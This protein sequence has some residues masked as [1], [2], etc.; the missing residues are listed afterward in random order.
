[1]QTFAAISAALPFL[2]AYLNPNPRSLDSGMNFAVAGATALP[3]HTLAEKSISSP[4]TNSSLNKQLDWMF[5]YFNGSV[6]NT[7]GQ[8]LI[9]DK[10]VLIR[11]RLKITYFT[12]MFDSLIDCLNKLNNTLFMVGEI[13]GNDYNYALFR[14]KSLEEVTL[15]V[16]DV[17]Q[18]IKEAATV[19]IFMTTWS[20]S[21][22]NVLFIMNTRSQCP[23]SLRTHRLRCHTQHLLCCLCR[24]CLEL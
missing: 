1:M 8:C 24:I 18:A 15:L 13:G 22:T 12:C 23:D 16:P 10:A 9:L 14:G 19:S 21:P 5:T 17:V 4:V 20:N 2:E 11:N 7:T 6:C 3:A